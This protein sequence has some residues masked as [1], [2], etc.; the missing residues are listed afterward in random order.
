VL[1]AIR[2]VG[3]IDPGAKISRKEL[4]EELHSDNAEVRSDALDRV[5][6]DSDAFR[7][8]NIKAALVNLLDR[9][10][11]VTLCCDNEGY[12]EYLS[13]LAE[14][15]AKV[16]NWNDSHQVCILANSLDLPDE[17]ANHAKISV[18][19]L[20]QRYEGGPAQTR[21]EVVAMLVQALGKGRTNLEA[22]TIHKI[23][24]IILS[25][26]HDTEEDVKIPTVEALKSSVER[27]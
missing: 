2:S 4:V 7:D 26:L 6:S 12:A 22:G 24:K 1:L 16:I 17:L 15:V 27:I 11:H 10:N 23:E 9:E 14:T 18:P 19:C 3:A 25:S 5:R 8:P 20:L 13:W 21:G